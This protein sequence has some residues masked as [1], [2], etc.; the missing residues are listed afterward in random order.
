MQ[1]GLSYYTGEGGVRTPQSGLQV[2]LVR[3]GGEW[4]T[5]IALIE[6]EQ[7]GYYEVDIEDEADQGYYEI[8]DNRTSPAGSFSGR[9][10]TIGQLDARGLQ[11]RCIY[12]NH[13]DNSVITGQKIAAGAID[14]SHLQDGSISMVKMKYH[15][16]DELEGVGNTSGQSPARVTDTIAQH[17]ID[18]GYSSIPIILLTPRCDKLLWVNSATLSAGVL[19]IDVGIGDTGNSN[20]I[21]YDIVILG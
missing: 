3:P 18:G 13:I 6:K 1:Y 15:V 14:S 11:D 19:T 5:G 21:R 7:T 8:W 20:H 12:T 4:A 9:T 17:K 16:S 2:R 10:V